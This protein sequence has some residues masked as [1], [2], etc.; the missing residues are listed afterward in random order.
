[1]QGAGPHQSEL[2]DRRLKARPVFGHE[3]I[4]A[5]HR[6]LRRIELA[7]AGVLE[8]LTRLNQWLLPYDTEPFD[9]LHPTI[10]ILNQPV[11]ADE[12]GGNRP[13]IADRDGVGETVDA[14]FRVRLIGQVSAL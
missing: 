4:V 1:M 11:A 14:F 10:G 9:F 3:K 13:M 2:V 7:A 12:L 6:A 8:R 5:V